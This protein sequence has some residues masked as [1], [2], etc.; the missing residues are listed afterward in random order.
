MI[1]LKK[2]DT[3]IFYGEIKSNVQKNFFF[4]FGRMVVTPKF[5]VK[6]QKILVLPPKIHFFY[7]LHIGSLIKFKM[8]KLHCKLPEYF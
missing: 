8:S 1:V 2:I 4:E 7:F 5:L 3:L 6:S